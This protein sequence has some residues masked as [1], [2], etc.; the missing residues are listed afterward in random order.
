MVIGGEEVEGKKKINVIN[1]ATGEVIDTV[2]A[3][4]KEDVR[5]AIDLAEDAFKEFSNLPLRERTKVLLKVAE[6]M[7]NSRE[8][9]ART[10]SLESGKPIRDAR[11]EVQRAI[12]L[13]RIAAEEARF[14]LEGKVHRVDAYEYPPGNENRLVMEVREP[15]GIVGAILPFNFPVNS[16]AHKVA[17]N[18]AAGNTVVVKPASATPISALEMAKILYQAGLPKGVLSVVPGSGSEVGDEIV[19][20]DK[21]RGIT[22]TGSTAVGLGIASKAV[23]KA[24]SIMMEMGGS[25]PIIVLEDA[26]LTRAVATA[27]RARFE[28]AGQNCN[29]GKR[30]FV[31][32]SIYEKFVKEYLEAAQKLKV[33][34]PLDE[35][36][37]VGP[38]ISEDA[39]KS[40][41]EFVK[42]AMNRGARVSFGGFRIKTKGFFFSPT[43]IEDVPIDA[44]AM[45]EEVFGPVAPIA[46]FSNDDEAVEMAN[47]TKYGL[48]SAVFTKD[49]RRALNIAKRLH[50]G[51]VMINDST[52]LRWDALPFGGVK[53]SGVGGREGVRN[54]ILNM[55]E[56]K[57]VSINLS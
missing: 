1:P 45:Q 54:T 40:M 7:E 46:R 29:A 10:L 33:G 49:L 57:I 51:G 3:A 36:T 27:V 50:F 26:D 18:L 32:E 31:H 21:V 53:M 6:I 12:S 34:D 4:S 37:D 44:K 35:T 8:R 23:A 2:E 22:F 55:T 42:D 20:N 11:V 43:V 30:I 25:D 39:V 16:F 52:R 9:L 15:I 19:E 5:R 47:S 14:V 17:P 38:V 24:K 13:F 28:Y 56:P 41:E 48:Q